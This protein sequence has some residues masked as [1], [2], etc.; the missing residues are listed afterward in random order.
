M[1]L[2]ALGAP[3]RSRDAALA[4][5]AV[6]DSMLGDVVAVGAVAEYGFGKVFHKAF[7]ARDVFKEGLKGKCPGGCPGLD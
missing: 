5:P 3:E 1:D 6:E 7:H 4:Y 2:P